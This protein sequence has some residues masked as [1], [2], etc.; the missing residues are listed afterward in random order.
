MHFT[1]RSTEGKEEVLTN[2]VTGG[3][4]ICLTVL[5]ANNAASLLDV[6]KRGRQ[7]FT[8]IF[9][10]GGAELYD[11]GT[12]GAGTRDKMEKALNRG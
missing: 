8:L 10:L 2:N 7:M 11:S 6:T 4:I 1:C 5:D 3:L 9:L 12:K